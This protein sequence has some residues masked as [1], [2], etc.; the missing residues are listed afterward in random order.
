MNLLV[1]K[2]EATVDSQ[3][4]SERLSCLSEPPITTDG[5]TVVESSSKTDFPDASLTVPDVAASEQ[6]PPTGG[7][8][9][10]ALSQS[11]NPLEWSEVVS[12]T[13]AHSSPT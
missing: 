1:S 5:W 2:A 7:Y 10:D 4:S 9:S 12:D 6:P 13:L 3:S 11:S 8:L